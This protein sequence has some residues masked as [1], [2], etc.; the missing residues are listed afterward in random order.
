LLLGEDDSHVLVGAAD[1]FIPV[2]DEIGVE[3]KMVP[4]LLTSGASF[5][6][7][8]KEKNDRAIAR[9]GDSETFGLVDDVPSAIASFLDRNLLI[10]SDIDVVL[11]ADYKTVYGDNSFVY[12]YFNHISDKSRF[13]N[14]SLLSGFYATNS[15]FALHYAVDMMQENKQIRNVLICNNLNKINLGLTLVQSLEA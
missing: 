11:F 7:M 12:T 5:F 3:L 13:V 1:E 6:I 2:L 4:V 8:S 14:Y 9:I 15:A 10:V